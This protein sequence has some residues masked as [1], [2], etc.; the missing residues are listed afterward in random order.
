M[1]ITECQNVNHFPPAF[2]NGKGQINLSL[3]CDLKRGDKKMIK[4]S[5]QEDV[6][7]RRNFSSLLSNSS[8]SVSYLD[9][10]LLQRE[11]IK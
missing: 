8:K 6:T 4:N 9:I 5:H 1:S 2:I 11:T 7:Q 10:F 3:T